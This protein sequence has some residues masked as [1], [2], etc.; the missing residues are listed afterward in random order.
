MAKQLA[1]LLQEALKICEDSGWVVPEREQLRA[2]NQR[3]SAQISELNDWWNQAFE[4]C[5][6]AE[7]K[8]RREALRKAFLSGFEAGNQRIARIASLEAERAV[9]KARIAKLEATLEAMGEHA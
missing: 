9:L 6:L 1:E 4:G 3:L 2:E 8:D 5:A 7:A